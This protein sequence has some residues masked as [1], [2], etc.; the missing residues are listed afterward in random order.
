MDKRWMLRGAGL[1]LVGLFALGCSG[2]GGGGGAIGGSDDGELR[3]STRNIKKGK[4]ANGPSAKDVQSKAKKNEYTIK[5]RDGAGVPKFLQNKVKTKNSSVDGAF[6]KL[7]VQKAMAVHGFTPKN[8]VLA[9]SLGLDRTLYI[10]TKKPYEQ[11]KKLEKN[12]NIEWVE[13]VT[14]VNAA[15]VNDPYYD[16]QWHMKMLD[17][18]KAWKTT[19]G[20]G[21]VVAVIDTGVSVGEDGFFKVL[22]GYDF[23][24]DDTDPADGNAHGT[25]VAGTIGQKANNGVGVVGVAP[26]VS[27]LPVK[28]LSDHGSG[29]NTWV[30]NGI[31]WAADHGA[32]VINMS[33]GGPM[34]SE[35]V[36]DACQY[37]YEQGVTV[38]AATGNDGYTDSI[39]YPAAYESTIAVGSVDPGKSIAFYSNQGKEIDLVGPGGDVT[40]DSNGDG[41]GDGVV[42]ETIEGG[43][44]GYSFFMGTSMATPHVAGVA[45]LVYAQGV[46]DPDDIRRI[47][48]KSA[49]DLG[50]KGWDTTYG[51]GLVNPVKALQMAG[52]GGEAASA[53]AEAVNVVVRDLGSDRAIIEWRTDKKMPTLLR[54]SDG[55]K[56]KDTEKV[57]LHRVTVDGSKGQK[58]K[59]T[60]GVGNKEFEKVNHTFK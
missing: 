41:Q 38:I 52:D 17:V 24:N 2:V 51:A 23:V 9:K 20:K 53:G 25:H 8:S 55:T 32:N 57:R 3:Q 37:A 30:A 14:E 45:A 56:I 7:D 60:V 12:K 43:Q 21:V 26:E 42:Q 27:I 4:K 40:V 11:V 46:H 34:P 18:E 16:Y 58:V 10:K 54:G 33:L 49:D 35:V 1:G 19:K 50:S 59:Y 36:A 31:I 48:R 15:G 47:L 5:L 6:G 28:V 29:S 44:W 39:G 13:Q 22:P